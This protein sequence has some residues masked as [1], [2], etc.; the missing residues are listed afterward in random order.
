MWLRQRFLRLGYPG[1]ISDIE[2]PVC[3]FQPSTSRVH[4]KPLSFIHCQSRKHPDGGSGS[5]AEKGRPSH[6]QRHQQARV[7]VVSG[8]GLS[9]GG[10]L[11]V[12]D[13]GKQQLMSTRRWC[14]WGKARSGDPSQVVDGTLHCPVL[15]ACGSWWLSCVRVP[16]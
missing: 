11:R 13:P 12:W 10:A 5:R 1:R 8:S 6:F 14:S 15:A 16:G 3:S 7:R 4:A 2:R 9:A